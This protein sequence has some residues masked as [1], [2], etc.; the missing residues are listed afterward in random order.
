MI[1]QD[2]GEIIFDPPGHVAFNDGTLV[3]VYRALAVA[4]IHVST[5][6]KAIEVVNAL[7]NEGILF[8]ERVF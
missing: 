7:Q 5:N 3:K 8:R 4:G 2:G 6:P 1:W